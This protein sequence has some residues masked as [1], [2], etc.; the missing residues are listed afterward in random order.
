MH[1]IA[2]FLVHVTYLVAL[3]L[4]QRYYRRRAVATREK[5]V[6]EVDQL[7]YVGKR[8]EAD[9]AEATAS[10]DAALKSRE[11]DRDKLEAEILGERTGR[12]EATKRAETAELIARGQA[13]HIEALQ[14][15]NDKM[16]SAITDM[17]RVGF[18]L[19]LDIA[20]PD[21]EGLTSVDQDDRHAVQHDASLGF[22]VD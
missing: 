12:A 5:H 11:R 17:R 16:L 18:A 21:P 3:V 22:T 9:L 14:R 2:E 8:L 1:L 15:S 7:L 4:L 6:N 19:P 13:K 20:D 10:R